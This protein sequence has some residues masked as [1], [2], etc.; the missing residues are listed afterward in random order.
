[1]LLSTRHGNML[2]AALTIAESLRDKK[3]ANVIVWKFLWNFKDFSLFKI[4]I[5]RPEA[6]LRSYFERYSL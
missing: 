4:L 1:M 3:I 5:H 2:H 6:S